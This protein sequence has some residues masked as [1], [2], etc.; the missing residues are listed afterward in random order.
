MYKMEYIDHPLPSA[1]N[2][3]GAHF[4]GYV[5]AEQ[6]DQPDDAEDESR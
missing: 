1:E 5:E 4:L 2:E 3:Q 6:T